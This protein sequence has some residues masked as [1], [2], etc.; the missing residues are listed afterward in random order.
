M[1][2]QLGAELVALSQREFAQI[3]YRVMAE[4]F[5]VHQNL[6]R[7]FDEKVYQSALASRVADMQTE[8]Q[9][10]VCFRDF[11]KTYFMDAVVANGAVFEL[12]AVEKLAAAH[13]GQL[14]NYLL[15]TGQHHGK[16]VNFR[17]DSVEHEFV[18]AMAT[19]AERTTFELN[20]HAW[21]STRG[22][23][24]HRKA[25]VIAMLEDWGV[26]LS[27]SLY[28]EA[29]LHFC[30]GPGQALTEVEVSLNQQC[31]TSQVVA[32]CSERTA[33]RVTTLKDEPAIRAY[34]QDLQRFIAS[35]TLDTVQW[36]NISH[37]HLTFTTLPSLPPHL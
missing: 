11:R 25:M 12:K 35:T 9:I 16:L 32:L 10:D 21:R 27:R 36:I 13:R 29:V 17:P 6:G 18:N 8:V 1:P 3:A 4:A 7:L 33:L 24:G 2:I 5:Q 37:S 34:A 26:G 22:F 19:L 20:D 31:I 23:G 15:L 30:G 28:E 14:L